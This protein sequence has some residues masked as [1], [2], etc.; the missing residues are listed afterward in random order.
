[1][2]PIHQLEGKFGIEGKSRPVNEEY[3]AAYEHLLPKEIEDIKKDKETIDV[4]RTKTFKLK[5]YGEKAEAA[6]LTYVKVA[7]KNGAKFVYVTALSNKKGE[8]GIRGWGSGFHNLP[9]EEFQKYSKKQNGKFVIQ[10]VP[11][12]EEK[13]KEFVSKQ[14]GLKWVG[15]AEDPGVS[16]IFFII[17]ANDKLDLK[18]FQLLALSSEVCDIQPYYPPEKEK[19]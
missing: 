18:G 5:I 9:F 11:G 15:P 17:E 14:V 13:F 1:M 10:I 19:K 3:V 2:P 7:T 12:E 16:P 6:D 8:K 4:A